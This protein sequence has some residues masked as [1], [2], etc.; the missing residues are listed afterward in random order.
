MAHLLPF[1]KTQ[2]HF[3]EVGAMKPLFSLPT[4]RNQRDVLQVGTKLSTRAADLAVPLL[5]SSHLMYVICCLDF[6]CPR[7]NELM[8][9]MLC[10]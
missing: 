4:E 3:E 8:L 2:Y 5:Q 10:A 1:P 9:G 7:S 6:P